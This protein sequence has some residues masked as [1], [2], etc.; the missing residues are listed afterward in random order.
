MC[1]VAGRSASALVG[2]VN[3]L[4]VRRVSANPSWCI[5]SGCV[6][7]NGPALGYMTAAIGRSRGLGRA[8]GVVGR[9][10]GHRSA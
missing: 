6:D 2:W 4:L 3:V 8:A 7:G 10:A 9:D 5:V 1:V